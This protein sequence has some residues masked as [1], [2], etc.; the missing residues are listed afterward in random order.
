MGEE[1]FSMDLDMWSGLVLLVQVDLITER[2]W[3]SVTGV[4]EKGVIL[5]VGIGVRR[6]S[7]KSVRFRGGC[8][9][10][11]DVKWVLSEFMLK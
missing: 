5:E 2:T 7:G 6:M 4:K 10:V 3:A 1:I 8:Q 9:F 11:S